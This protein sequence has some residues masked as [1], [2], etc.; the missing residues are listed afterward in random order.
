MTM[1]TYLVLA[2][3]TGV[4]STLSPQEVQKVVQKYMSWSEE[5][6]KAGRVG[7]AEKLRFGEGRVLRGN[8]GQMAVTDGPYAETKEIVGGFWLIEAASYDEM[9]K[10]LAD[11]PHL[12]S[13]GS[14]EVREIE[15]MSRRG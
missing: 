11:H 10:L 13:P 1:A 15:D 2:R 5:L 8:G 3:G 7:H 12:D 4:P 6:R 14:L 9:L